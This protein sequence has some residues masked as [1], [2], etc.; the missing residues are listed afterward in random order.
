M[1]LED[2][3]ELEGGNILKSVGKKVYEYATVRYLL[4]KVQ[5]LDSIL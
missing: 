4:K 3:G 5:H 1:L 2:S